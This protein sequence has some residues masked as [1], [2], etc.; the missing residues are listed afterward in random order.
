MSGA[1]G[2]LRAARC[3]AV[4]RFA[5][6]YST[7]KTAS[8]NAAVLQRL[9]RQTRTVAGKITWNQEPQDLRGLPMIGR[10]VQGA[11]RNTRRG[12]SLH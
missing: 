2:M 6:G 10:G 8:R 4:A 7:Q 11:L 3:L 1:T 12:D 5:K 9:D